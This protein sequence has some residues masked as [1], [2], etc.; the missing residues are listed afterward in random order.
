MFSLYIPGVSVRHDI[1]SHDSGI[2]WLELLEVGDSDGMDDGVLNCN[3]CGS[4]AQP[5][6]VPGIDGTGVIGVAAA[7][8]WHI[9]LGDWKTGAGLSSNFSFAVM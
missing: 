5:V 4:S 6:G 9:G 1:V 7:C 3:C 2:S 8:C